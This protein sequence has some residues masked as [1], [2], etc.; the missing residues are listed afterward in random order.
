MYENTT[1][2]SMPVFRKEVKILGSDGDPFTVNRK[3]VV[4]IYPTVGD[5]DGDRVAD[6]VF[7]GESEQLYFARG[8]K[9]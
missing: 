8:I 1:H 4:H 3:E 7:G 5:V 9:R 6:V 2:L